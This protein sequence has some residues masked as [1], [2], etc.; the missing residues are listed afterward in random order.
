[1]IRAVVLCAIAALLVAMGSARAELYRYRDPQ[2]GKMK[3]TTV[4][5][6][7]L[8]NPRT[9]ARGPKVEIIREPPP[10]V[11]PQEEAAPSDAGAK[12]PPKPVPTQ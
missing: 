3:Y 11:A 1:M 2:T 6:P 4:P 8:K 9:A 7:W 10:S 5:P 12:T